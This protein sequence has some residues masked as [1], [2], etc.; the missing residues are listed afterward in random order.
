MTATT[1]FHLR[2]IERSVPHWAR[3]IP[4]PHI[5]AMLGTLRKDYLQDDGQPFDWHQQATDPQR[6][7][8]DDALEQRDRSRSTLNKTLAGL[9]GITEFCKPLL[10]QRLGIA[11]PVDEAV[12]FYQ[13]FR[14]LPS[15][16]A[17]PEAG[18]GSTSEP[19]RFK[20]D[21]DGTPR[22]V[23]LLE[24]ALHNFATDDEAGPYS[25]LQTSKTQIAPLVG[26]TPASFV[27]ACRSLDLGGQY[28]AHIRSVYHSAEQA[29]L[30]GQFIQASR[31]ELL[32]QAQIALLRGKLSDA[33][34]EAVRQLCTDSLPAQ[35]KCWRLSLYQVP[36][37][38]IMVIG[39]HADDKVR[40]CIIYIPGAHD[41]PLME[42]PSARAAATALAVRLQDERLLQRVIRCAPQSLQPKL[43]RQLRA[44]LFETLVAPNIPATLPR[45]AP[46][47]RYQAT[48]ELPGDLWAFLYRTHVDRVKADAATLAVP[49]AAVDAA[50]RVERLEHWLSIG[51]DLANVAAMF[52]PGL[53][54]V[55]LAV[56]GAQLMNSVFHGIEAWEAGDKAEAAAQ[57]ESV[58]LNLALVGVV[59]AGSALLRPS[60]FVDS[61]VPIEHA[62]G[63]RLWQPAIERYASPEV[64]PDTVEANEHG[65]YTHQQRH[66]IRLDGTLYEQAE[67]PS[68]QWRIHHP[69]E[70]DAYRPTA[71]P[72]GEGAW[73]ITGEHPLDWEPGQLLRR[74]GPLT[75]T[76][77]DSDLETAL[78]CTDTDE[79]VLRH[80]HVSEDPPP[81]LLADAIERL[82][83]DQEASEL[84]TRVRHGLSVAPYKHYA[85]NA[86]VELQGWPSDHV[87]QVFDGPE[88]WGNAVTYGDSAGATPV[89]IELTRSDLELGRLSQAV[90]DQL[91]EAVAH[92]LITAPH[93][94]SPASALDD[95][96]ADHLAA[97]RNALYEALHDGRQQPL[98]NA[99]EV[100]KRQFT[101][102]PN[103]VLNQITRQAST[104][105]RARML[106]GR[107]PLRIAEEA[108]A[109][110]AHV[111]LD[112]ALLGLYRPG[113][114]NADSQR[115]ANALLAERPGAS[116]AEL[117]QA[118]LADR[119]RAAQLIG[120]QP[121]R[122]GY[123]SPMRL[124]DGRFGYPLSGRGSWRDWIRL[125]GSS[126][127]ERRLQELYP[128]L[129]TQAR[130]ALLEQL[131]Q[132]GNVAEQLSH[133]QRERA[134]LDEALRTWRDAAEGDAREERSAF[135]QAMQRAARRDDGTTLHLQHMTLA[136]LPEL[137][138]RFD[139]IQTL[140]IRG[141]G[142]DFLPAGFFEAFPGLRQLSLVGNPQLQAETLFNAL[143]NAPQLRFLEVLDSPLGH[144]DAT[145]REALRG[146]R[147][148]RAL[149]FS[150]NQL[151]I[152]DDSLQLLAGLPLEEL[153]LSRNQVTLTPALAARFG[154]MRQLRTLNLSQNP[155]DTPPHLASLEL[156]R[157]LT[158]NDCRLSAWPDE[159]TTL[160]NR[161]D[162]ALR[163]LEL[164]DNAIHELPTLADIL[165]TPYARN[166]LTHHGQNWE[167]H[168][169]GLSPAA[170]G[171]LRAIGVAI[172]EDAEFLPAADAV[173]WRANGDATQQLL[174]D[175]LFDDGANPALREVIERVGRSAQAQNNQ[176]SL[177]REIWQLLEAASQDQA[178]R[179]HLNEVAGDFPATCGDAGADGFS[180]LQV[181]L[182]A[183]AESSQADIPGP[184]LFQF[185]LRLLRREQVNR[186]A[187]RI[188][189]ARFQRQRALLA[190]EHLPGDSRPAVPQL[191]DLD[192][193]DDITD[194]ELL[195]GGLDDIEIRLALRQS[196][197]G[198]LEFPEPSQDMLYRRDAYISDVVVENVAE[199]VEAFADAPGTRRAWIGAQPGWQRF[200]RRRYA[201]RFDALNARWYQG[202][203][204][205]QYCLDADSDAVTT[206]APSVREALNEVLPEAVPDAAGRLPRLK[207]GSQTYTTAL[208]RLSSGRQAEED[209][210][211]QRLTDQQDPNK[212]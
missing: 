165:A 139:H 12:Y 132:R 170:A 68:G 138:A 29:G 125:G 202:M 40:P 97:R 196:L 56:G 27:E 192:P 102:L 154:E 50:A 14:R 206:L 88:P 150:N 146:M 112:R 39:M 152:T 143:R 64:L 106:G 212:R 7:A 200:L 61:L 16:P 70:A 69:E 195:E 74:L 149:R 92:R 155:L 1:P 130:R 172:M 115:L 100:L 135:G 98:D 30:A 44:Q 47:L 193:L 77:S 207:L 191:P 48:E 119:R 54:I 72:V 118:A 188:Q 211:Y 32:A 168:F 194:A 203:E 101:S 169:N 177:A 38:E 24:A 175:S 204:Y 208:A 5:T 76:L 141:L 52:V 210:L 19:D 113:L 117:L 60:R 89:V 66:F 95:L 58:M 187:A 123:R 43:A 71:R 209:A 25:L 18:L 162:Y 199:E 22:K 161:H 164:S 8:L 2:Q 136:S 127:E 51:L 104:A 140:H 171:P 174:W 17:E 28:Q 176:R 156:L 53:N 166:L 13:P 134:A 144:L 184:Y 110:Q 173:D 151:A 163:S 158:L 65:Q 84:I 82:A 87:L 185:Y 11:V 179:E 116:N 35:L 182:M 91:D 23:T 108:R 160:M 49:T 181:E 55:M 103:R 75:D 73:R 145:A 183:Y 62:G 121:I 129:S 99:A 79:Q 147:H 36:L 85:L 83:S 186:L 21:P 109:H 80:L 201:A 10:E 31:D 63:E 120:Q 197:A 15:V 128:A 107:V 189:A 20:Y 131:R 6:Q 167:F 148:L 33:G 67:T 42:Y 180:T 157:N 178:L 3:Q 90:L 114:A 45:P 137:P 159:L 26:W 34:L 126:I 122:P 142:L 46:R 37:H 198:Q 41:A 59:G 94:T 81:A 190:L 93:P 96:L 153:D 4:S 9:Q 78:R 133:L 111:R 86:L 205:L 57:L 124:A 105:E